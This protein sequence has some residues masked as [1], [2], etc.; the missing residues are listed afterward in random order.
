M[1]WYCSASTAPSS[2]RASTVGVEG[3]EEG[4]LRVWGGEG[5]GGGGEGLEEGVEGVGKWVG[6][7]G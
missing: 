7:G 3:L 2:G 4:V 6:G 5:F 1:A